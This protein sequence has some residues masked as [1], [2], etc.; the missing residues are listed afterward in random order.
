MQNLFIQ[1]A[2]TWSK[3]NHQNV[4][5]FVGYINP[6]NELAVI[7][8]FAAGGSLWDWLQQNWK[9]KKFP[10][11]FQLITD[12]AEGLAHL[13]SL[14]VVH[15]DL[16]AGNVVL[17]EKD[18]HALITDFGLARLTRQGSTVAPVTQEPLAA[19]PLESS[20]PV[21]SWVPQAIPEFNSGVGSID[22]DIY[23][24]GLLALEVLPPTIPLSKLW[25]EGWK[26][27][28]SLLSR[29]NAKRPVDRPVASEVVTEIRNM[30]RRF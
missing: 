5:P 28:S 13:H 9:E 20:S 24:F 19:L 30:R 22:S 27:L 10:T 8:P 23:L 2:R 29:C 12:I 18:S 14:G 21:A 4:L 11:R 3:V 7:T 15:G 26:P 1:E 17:W 16:H 6:R 25:L